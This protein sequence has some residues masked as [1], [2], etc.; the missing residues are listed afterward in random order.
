[1]NGLPSAHRCRGLDRV[2]LDWVTVL[3]AEIGQVLVT[4][5]V[6]AIVLETDQELETVR[7]TG[8][9]W[10]IDHLNFPVFR[11]A[12][13]VCAIGWGTV[14]RICTP[15]GGRTATMEGTTT[16]IT[17]ITVSGTIHGGQLRGGII[18]GI[19]TR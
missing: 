3:V 5:P 18:G 12:V 14:R 10:A 9:V 4:V 2:G 19:V 6:L 11:I 15:T 13:I 8:P 7:A 16:I 17:G 1:M